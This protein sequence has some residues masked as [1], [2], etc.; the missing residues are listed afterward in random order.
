MSCST[1]GGGMSEQLINLHP[2]AESLASSACW[3]R[4][5]SN[6]RTGAGGIGIGTGK[7]G[8]FM[9]GRTDQGPVKP[10]ARRP[11]RRTYAAQP[12]LKRNIRYSLYSW[13]FKALELESV[14][15]CCH[16]FCA[17]YGKKA[18]FNSLGK[19]EDVKDKLF[20]FNAI[21]FVRFD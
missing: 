21:W 10:Q 6:G 7:R 14:C 15:W 13:C 9:H 18:H 5:W 4:P 12:R 3:T 19:L 20:H 11:A 16:T 1:G 8:W 2:P 17:L